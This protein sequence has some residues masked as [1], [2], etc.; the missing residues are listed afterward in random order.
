MARLD[1]YPIWGTGLQTR[2]FTYVRDTVTG[3]ALAGA[4]F[5]GFETINVG[6][7]I[8][9]TIMDLL[10]VIFQ[11]VRWRPAKIERQTDK[12]T[13][14]RSRAADLAKSRARLNWAPEVSLA[15][16]VACTTAW[17]RGIWDDTRRQCL[18][19]LLM[20]RG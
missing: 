16:G 18:D 15:E 4:V 11:E 14:V 2:N 6:T 9:H 12:P 19:K 5:S 17:Y 20:E 1:P 13:G 10:E 3:M 7:D 8:H